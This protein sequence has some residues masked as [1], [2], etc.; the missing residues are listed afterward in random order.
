ML[1][2][3]TWSRSAIWNWVNGVH[4]SFLPPDSCP[5]KFECLH[6]LAAALKFMEKHAVGF[7][8]GS[9]MTCFVYNAALCQYKLGL[10]KGWQPPLS[11]SIFFSTFSWSWWTHHNNRPSFFLP[12]A[13][14]KCR[15]W[16]RALCARY[17]DYWVATNYCRYDRI[18]Y[19]FCLFFYYIVWNPLL[20]I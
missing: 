13:M 15:V 16:P 17:E 20:F 8:Y 6:P 18:T 4:P 9:T 11:H 1:T 12:L 2:G 5:S 3:D 10:V 7:S 14:T 19:V